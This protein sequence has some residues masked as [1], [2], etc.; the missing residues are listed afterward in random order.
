MVTASAGP[1][2]WTGSDVG[3][4]SIRAIGERKTPHHK[5]LNL[6]KTKR[7]TPISPLVTYRDHCPVRYKMTV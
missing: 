1:V 5:A 4:K 2:K 3:A 6:L 7:L